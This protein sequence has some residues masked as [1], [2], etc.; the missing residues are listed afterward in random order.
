VPFRA[1]RGSPRILGAM[2]SVVPPADDILRAL[3]RT[4]QVRQFTGEAVSEADLHEILRVAR[5]S[6]SS[7][8]RQPWTLIVLRDP[9]LRRRIAEAAPFARHAAI[10]PV[11]IAVAM[12][13][14][15]A[16]WETYDEGR[17]VERMLVAAE[18]LGLGA[19]IGWA[20]AK[21]RPVVNGLLG[22]PEPAYVRSFVSIGHPTAEA[23]A[24]KSRP[25]TARKPLEEI[26][27]EDRYS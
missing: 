12:P 10:A 25:G 6:G 21:E 8:N 24:P 4:R 11:A 17:L 9:G 2:T 19:G 16:E 7:Q 23:A 13:G 20:T 1:R 5:W 22:V 26:L 3:R 15:N 14:T 27:R 18:A